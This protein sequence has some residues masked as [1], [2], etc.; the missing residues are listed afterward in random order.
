MIV[1]GGGF[2]GVTAARELTQGGAQVLLLEGKDRL[3]GRAW[4]SDLNGVP[5]ELGG[6]YVHWSQ[7]HLWAE[8]S[9]YNLAIVERPSYSS[10]NA[11]QKTRFLIDGVL[12]QDFTAEQTAAIKAAFK[13]FVAPAAQVFPQPF[14]P[15]AREAYRDYDGLS[16][17][18]RIDQM[19]LTELQRATLKRT[20]AMQCNNAPREGGYIEALRWFALANAH[21]ETYA[22]SVSRFTLAGGTVQLLRA[23]AADSRADIRLGNPVSGVARTE[24]GVSVKA[25][26]GRFEARRC[27]VATG[28]NVWKDIAFTPGLSPHKA[29]LTQEELSGKGGKIYVSLRGRFADSRWSAIGMPILSVLPHVIGEDSSVVVVFTNPENPLPDITRESLQAELARFDPDVAVIDFAY[30]D[31]VGDPLV[32]GTWGN[33]R[34]GQ[35]SRY[36]ADALQPEGCVHFASS[37]IARGWR[38]FFDGAI[39]SG[40]RVARD[41]L[42]ALA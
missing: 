14:D 37:D 16:S 26:Q 13:A 1:I 12:Q 6:G 11:M 18:D 29:A 36:F 8:V 21:D 19:A 22:A 7:P 25:A 39:E 33:F 42:R 23:I 4:T 27:I 41:V 17:Q 15:F 30:H 20:S 35:F 38:G 9:R 2:A 24:S 3:G 10:T 32:K 31:W 40:T 34:P 28:V 5:I